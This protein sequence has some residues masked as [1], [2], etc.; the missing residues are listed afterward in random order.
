M[1]GYINRVAFCWKGNV[2]AVHK[3]LWG[4]EQVSFEPIHYLALLEKNPGALD[5]ARPLENW[6]LPDCFAVLRRC[7]ENQ[8]DR[9]EGTRE[10]IQVLR[11]LEKRPLG[12][13]TKAVEK[14]L[15]CGWVYA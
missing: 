4:K 11:L 1:K 12:K 2:V 7:L 3:R 14:S 6:S 13:L 5:H 8:F 10:Y 15:A 9:G